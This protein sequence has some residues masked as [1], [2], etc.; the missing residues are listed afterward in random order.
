MAKRTTVRRRFEHRRSKRKW[1]EQSRTLPRGIHW[2]PTP[3]W[4][5]KFRPIR[6]TDFRMKTP[7]DLLLATLQAD[8]PQ[9]VGLFA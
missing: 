1:A 4:S 7:R 8:L 6:Q 9:V 3:T 5:I 2:Q